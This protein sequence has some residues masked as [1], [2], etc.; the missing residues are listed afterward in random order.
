M[1]NDIFQDLI[2]EEIMVMYLDNILIFTRIVEE[3][4]W[5]VQRVLEILTKHKLFLYPKKCEFQK[6]RIE[7]L[8][9]IISE[10]KVFMDPVKVV[11]V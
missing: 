7:Y 6:T 1:M 8:D 10:N 5:T 2:A 4:V 11:R 9:L 3:H